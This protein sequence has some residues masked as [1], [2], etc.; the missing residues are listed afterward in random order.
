MYVFIVVMYDVIYI[1]CCSTDDEPEAEV[2]CAFERQPQA[3]V[4]RSDRQSGA[5]RQAPAA[6]HARA[7]RID[8]GSP[9]VAA[10]RRRW[11]R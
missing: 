2:G 9:Q 1:L 11:R 5:V 10:R 4:V 6:D 8:A 3:R 7:A